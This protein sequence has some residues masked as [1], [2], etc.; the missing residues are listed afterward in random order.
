MRVLRIRSRYPMIITQPVAVSN[1]NIMCVPPRVMSH[2]WLQMFP[3][4]NLHQP[5]RCQLCT[6]P[7]GSRH[8]KCSKQ[9]HELERHHVQAST[10]RPFT[11]SHQIVP[12]AS[13]MRE[14]ERKEGE[15]DR[16]RTA[17]LMRTI[18]HEDSIAKSER[19]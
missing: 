3:S 2:T 17:S 9:L 12:F 4:Y 18:V 14:K 11:A 15:S 10:A 7:I 19:L 13:Q 5:R 1:Q 16:S 8:S 6:R